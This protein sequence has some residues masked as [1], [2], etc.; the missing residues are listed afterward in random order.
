VRYVVEPEPLG[1][2]GGIKFASRGITGT[3]VVFNGDV[4]TEIDLAAVIRLHRERRARATIVLTPV[5][6]PRA[7]GLVETD[8]EQNILR[9]LEKPEGEITTNRIN[10]GIYVLEPDT[11]DRIPDGQPVSIER[12]YFPSLVERGETFLAYDYTGYWIDIG[13][14]E[15]YVQVHQDIM[16]G[17]FGAVPFGGTPQAV[18]SPTATV[19]PTAVIDSPCFVDDDV[20]IGPGARVGGY[21]VV[22]RGTRLGANSSVDHAILWPGCTV[23]EGTSLRDVVAGR[24]CQFGAHVTVD[25]PAIFGDGTILTDYT[26]G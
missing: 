10:A 17:R 14:R 13:T 5:E 23:G 19:S 15:K 21:T 6:N 8:A 3:T 12:Q 16:A 24:G 2:A 9:F 20:V 26:R 25:G 1:T 4:L 7:Y 18:V 22:G 11:F